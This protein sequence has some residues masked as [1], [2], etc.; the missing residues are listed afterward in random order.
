MMIEIVFDMFTKY[1]SSN[2][3]SGDIIGLL[4]QHMCPLRIA[5]LVLIVK[6]LE[7]NELLD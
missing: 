5:S 4:N 2:L 7:F 6:W 1:L 3:V